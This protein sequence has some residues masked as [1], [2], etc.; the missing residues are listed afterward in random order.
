MH[1]RDY[2]RVRSESQASFAGRSGISQQAVSLICHGSPPRLSTAKRV[3]DATRD[4][5][6]PCG[7]TVSYEDLLPEP[8][9]LE[10]VSA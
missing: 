6:A 7:G 4:E 10:R 5:P 2:L 1:L 8:S 9:S 3:V